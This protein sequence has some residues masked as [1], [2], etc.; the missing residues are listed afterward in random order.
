MKQVIKYF[1]LF[2]F[3][4]GVYYGIEWAF[5]QYSHPSMFLLGGICFIICGV[6]NEILPSELPLPAQMLL[7]SLAIT[8]LELIFGYILNIKMGL[9][10]WDYSG[11][12]LNFKGQICLL[13]SVI[14]FFMGGIAI[15][16]D[17]YIRYWFF[18]EEKPAYV[19]LRK[20]KEKN[21]K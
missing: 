1:F 17:D 10:I 21:T 19:F 15:I 18:D 7:C 5:R 20:T 3:G 2:C 6:F 4:G 8:T 16:V 13:F 11:H 14:W 12:F 9:R